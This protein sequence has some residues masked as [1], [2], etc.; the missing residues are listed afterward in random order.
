M[1]L[2]ALTPDKRLSE[3]LQQ[4]NRVS[5]EQ[6]RTTQAYKATGKP[7]EAI[8]EHRNE[9]VK[10]M[11]DHP[12]CGVQKL[13]KLNFSGRIYAWL[14]RNDYPWLMQH[15]PKKKTSSVVIRNVDYP[16]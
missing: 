8:N 16:G 1:V 2:S 13:R 12:D 11:A 10:L 6:A 15:C 9:W 7:H 14:Y 5:S 3:I 4:V